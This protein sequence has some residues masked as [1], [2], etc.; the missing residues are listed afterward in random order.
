M[1]NMKR[2]LYMVIFYT[3]LGRYEL[4]NTV[5]GRHPVVILNRREYCLSIH[6]MIIWS[7]LMWSIHTHDELKKVFYQKEREAHVLGDAG[8]E[9]YLARMERRGLIMSGKGYTGVEALYALIAR[10]YIIPLSESLFTK[11]GA[12]LHLTFRRRIP[13]AVTKKIFTNPKL[14]PKEKSLLSLARQAPLTTDDLIRCVDSGAADI[15][16]E[17]KLM[18][19]LYPAGIPASGSRN[20]FT[21]ITSPNRI[22]VTQAVVNL[23]LRKQILFEPI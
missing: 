22:P 18:A 1:K 21:G 15:S 3:A 6:E 13:F 12:F 4:R 2:G 7:S 23:Y 19:A 16:T 17:S 9:D 20:E 8:F 14:C 5:D 11:L 10:L